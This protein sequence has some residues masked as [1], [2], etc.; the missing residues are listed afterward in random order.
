[1]NKTKAKFH[2]MLGMYRISGRPDDPAPDPAIFQKSG[3][4]RIHTEIRPATG[5]LRILCRSQTIC[6]GWHN[7]HNYSNEHTPD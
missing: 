6:R 7:S 2:F 5:F 4:G 3:S 1:M